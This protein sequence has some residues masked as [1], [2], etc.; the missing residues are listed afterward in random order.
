MINIKRSSAP[1]NEFKY[2]DIEIIK[3]IREDFF[4]L[5]YLCEEYVPVHFEIDHFYPIGK[6]EFN[7]LEHCW[8]NLFYI[9]QK[10][11]K[12]R[13]KDT[14]AKGKEVYNNCIEDV[15]NTINLKFENGKIE[16]TPIEDIDKSKNTVKLLNRIYN[17]IG[18]N[19]PSYI[20]RREEI[21]KEIEKFEDIVSKYNKVPELFELQLKN[22]IS[23]KTK[24][25]ASAY[26]SFKRQIVRE[27][28]PDLL[29][30]I[31]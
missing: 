16:I 22:R 3:K 8:D 29:K 18:T 21:K 23:K 15:E 7:H 10:C 4:I 28:Y 13:P 19:S 1:E 27:K 20:Y 5:C 17:G 25:E 26:V 11:N 31:D 24:S 14:N 30:F 6:P 12:I 2:N 9:C